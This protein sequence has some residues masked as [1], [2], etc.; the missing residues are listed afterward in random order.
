MKETFLVCRLCSFVHINMYL[1][2]TDFFRTMALHE[3]LFKV[4]VE[5]KGGKSTEVPGAASKNR[6]PEDG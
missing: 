5:I 3:D 2:G 4:G 1:N 6:P